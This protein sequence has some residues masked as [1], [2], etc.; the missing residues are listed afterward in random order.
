MGVTL[1]QCPHCGETMLPSWEDRHM[2]DHQTGDQ[3]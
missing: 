2:I 1:W 3:T